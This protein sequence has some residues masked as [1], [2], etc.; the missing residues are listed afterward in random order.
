MLNGSERG[1]L[2]GSSVCL[3]S[4]GF[5]GQIKQVKVLGGLALNDVGAVRIKQLVSLC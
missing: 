5:V 3:A 4:P 1:R 2:R